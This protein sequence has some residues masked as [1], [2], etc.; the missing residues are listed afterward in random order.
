MPEAVRVGLPIT[1]DPIFPDRC[2]VCLRERPWAGVTL[3]ISNALGVW[4]L[5]GPRRRVR[6][7]ACRRCAWRVRLGRLGATGIFLAICVVALGIQRKF[8]P[9][10]SGMT[11]KAVGAGIAVAI[12]VPLLLWQIFRAA[13]VD[14]TRFGDS[15]IYE[16][17]DP[18]YARE[19]ARRNGART[20]V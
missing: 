14:M 13:P 3:W 19:F 11:A 9:G 7:P 17:R 20:G 15:L 10:L 1:H 12:G 5:S 8:F 2:V 6:F 4:A 16:F 18:D